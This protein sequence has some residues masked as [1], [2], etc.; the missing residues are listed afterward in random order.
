M[1]ETPDKPLANGDHFDP[2][3]DFM[4]DVCVRCVHGGLPPGRCALLRSALD[5]PVNELRV[6]DGEETCTEFSEVVVPDH[7]QVVMEI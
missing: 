6:I 5:G 2:A 3:G 4:A 1:S 7:R